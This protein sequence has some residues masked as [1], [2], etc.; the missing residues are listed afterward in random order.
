M[1]EFVYSARTREGAIKKGKKKARSKDEIV[2]ILQGQ[3]LIVVDVHESVSLSLDKLKEINVGGVP[4]K[5][6]VL[7]FRQFATMTTAALP[8]IQS[9]RILEQQV[10]NPRFKRVLQDVVAS[11]EGGSTLSSAFSKYPDVF[12]SVTVS[13]IKA[14]EESGNLGIIL[15]ELAQELEKQKKLQG[16]IKSALIYPV[17]ILVVVVV[18]VILLLTVLVPAIEAIFNDL[19]AAAQLPWS[20]RMIITMSDFVI[21]KG[22]YILVTIVLFALAFRYHYSRPTGRYF[23]HR[24]VLKIPQVGTLITKMQVAQ[25]TRVF[26]LLMK[27]GVTITKALELTAHSLTN[28][29]FRE[30][31]QSAKTEVSKGTPLSRHIA[32]AEH[33]PLIV[34]QMIAV[35][36]ESG[37]MVSVLEKLSQYYTEEV[38]VA[39]D[40][41]SSII[42]P[43]MLILMGVIISF[44]A[45]AVY[46]PMFSL[47]NAIS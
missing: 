32:R 23:Y 9:L 3:G 38:D 42:E 41:M 2:E 31:V 8:I 26:A 28:E 47:S 6:K 29:L 21:S 34:S 27:S 30:T 20:T 44:V 35:G 24:M 15:E 19:G 17:I 14:G 7:F 16:K 10:S 37:E 25:F 43:I 39:T 12:D 18:V 5:E 46:M 4:I 1:K 45:M 22:V 33:F 11:I 36:E 40:N 13:M